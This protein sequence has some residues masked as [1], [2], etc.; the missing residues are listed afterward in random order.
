M[1]FTKER[2]IER[3]GV[4]AK[5]GQGSRPCFNKITSTPRAE[6]TENER[7]SHCKK[8]SSERNDADLLGDRLGEGR[9]IFCP[10]S[11]APF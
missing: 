3:V 11:P 10:D 1:L 9:F 5:T 8:A 6:G 7:G 2:L 4:G